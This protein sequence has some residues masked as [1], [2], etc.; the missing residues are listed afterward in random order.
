M[1]KPIPIFLFISLLAS[2]W[3]SEAQGV[4]D[5]Y[6]QLGL[7]N[8]LVLREKNI[9]IEQSLLALKDA[10]S[11]FLPAV[12]F[13]ASYSLANGGRTI[14]FPL[15]DLFND[16]YST[17]NQLTQSNQF[18]QL[19]NLSEQFLPNNFYDARF[20]V[21][22]PLINPD[23]KYQKSVRAQQL[24]I[25]EYDL[26]IYKANLI[27]D[28]RVAYY[29]FCTAHT[30]I[31]VIKSSKGLVEQNL[32]DNQSLLKNGRGLPASVL[33]AESEVENINA[34]MIEAE[35]RERNAGYYLNFLLNQPLDSKVIFEEQNPDWAMIGSLLA[36]DN[37]DFRPEIQQI[38]TAQA[39]QQTLLK[40]S[41]NYWVPRLSTFADIGSQAFDFEF[42]TQSSAYLFF[43]L[44]LGIPVFQGG[45]NKN[46]IQRSA[47][48]L[49][50]ISNQKELLENKLSLDLRRAKNELK[51][52]EAAFRSAE[53]KLESSAAYLRLVDRGFK[54]G[55]NSL[56][57]F[58]D[59]RNQ[60]TQASLQKTINAY[61]LLQ[62]QAS[63]ERQLLT[64]TE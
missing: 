53:K 64:E 38:N 13:G 62:A 37:L 34:L 60:F 47:L 11:Y 41:Q 16:V 45:R 59:A 24:M 14:D 48:E 31:E 4:L 3:T 23:L 21:S 54:E 52:S 43:G 29:Q 26:A 6:I 12:D 33:R 61:A 39:I 35:N 2:P 44:N 51:T 25:S 27:E 55:A 10:K 32:R 9:S 50:N 20:R 22:M 1:K 40:S 8:N 46:Q 63:L 5:E 19:E 28:I 7:K 56:I 57:E 30:A 42:N 49:E 18:P 58:I 15:G 36:E 17:L